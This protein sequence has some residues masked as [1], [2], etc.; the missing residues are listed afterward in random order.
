MTVGPTAYPEGYL[1]D[2]V[3]WQELWDEDK[4]YGFSI[5]GSGSSISPSSVIEY[6]EA[7]KNFTPMKTPV[8]SGFQKCALNSWRHTWLMKKFRPCMVKTNGTVDYFLNPDDISKKFESTVASDIA[9]TSYD[10]NAMVQIGQIWINITA[11]EEVSE[12][13]KLWKKFSVRFS[14]KK[15]DGYECW[16]HYNSQNK[17][18]PYIYHAMF[19]SSL[20]KAGTK[21]E[22]KANKSPFNAVNGAT[23]TTLQSMWSMHNLTGDYNWCPTPWNVVTLF[24]YLLLLFF[25]TPQVGLA[26]GKGY[27]FT[28]TDAVSWPSSCLNTSQGTNYTCG[29]FGGNTQPYGTSGSTGTDASVV[30]FFIRHLWGNCQHLV[31]GNFM[32]LANYYVKISKGNKDGSSATSYYNFS[33]TVYKGVGNYPKYATTNI[34]PA[35]RGWAMAQY[36]IFG[37]NDSPYWGLFPFITGSDGTVDKGF[38]GYVYFCS[39]SNSY[40]LL[41]GGG[42]SLSPQ[43]RTS[44]FSYNYGQLMSD[45]LAFTTSFLTYL[46][47]S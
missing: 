23:Y 30:A 7:N 46:P 22:S 34:T 33:K 16:T 38:C 18:V 44:P 10:G 12:D 19:E 43:R 1:K 8:A 24:Q 21:A 42:V 36:G 37:L 20:N 28:K 40:P 15:R 4:I 27:A 9:N 25:K 39:R 41:W 17:L 47:E 11:D 35:C 14:C 32:N 6:I 5:T 31:L 29:M 3:L 45:G 26:C 13:N 2:K